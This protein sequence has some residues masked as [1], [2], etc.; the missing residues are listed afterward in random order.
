M[1][2]Q[3]LTER[4]RVFQ[5]ADPRTVS[6]YV[7]LHVGQHRIGLAKTTHPLASLKHRR[8]ADLDLCRISYGGSVR[9]TSP[10]LEN[11]YHLQVL[12]SGNCLWRGRNR[13]HYL[14]PGELL[15]IN[16]DDAVDLTYSQDCEKFILKMPVKLLESVCDEQRWLRPASGIRFLC[17]HYRLSELEG[18]LGLLAMVCQESEASDPQLR[19]QE[20]YTQ[21]VGSKL[22][23]L[24]KTNVSRECLGS[25]I[26][27][28]E[29]ILDYVESN[30]KQELSGED[31]AERAHMSLRSLYA[32]FERQLGITPLQY[33]RQRKLER[34]H[35][36]LSDSNCPVRSLTE[37][38]LDYG[39]VHLGRFSKSYLLQFGEL[40]SQTLKR[41][42]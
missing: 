14:L 3:L 22:L 24:M 40:P 29:R 2:S 19:V 6:D 11:I 42:S 21:I 5:N 4:S 28:F 37:V 18:F 23:S 27:S 12:L 1:D 17:N 10:A 8:F 16:P 25:P 31:L 33:I 30:L 38:A 36:C 39:F 32:L 35:N 41:R 7:N 9:V 26:G 34:I 13:E 15:L 20:H